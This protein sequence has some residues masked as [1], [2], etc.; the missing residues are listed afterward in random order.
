MF[1]LCKWYLFNHEY[2]CVLIGWKNLDVNLDIFADTELK[3]CWVLTKSLLPIVPVPYLRILNLLA[4]NAKKYIWDF[5]CTPFPPTNLKGT[6]MLIREKFKWNPCNNHDMYSNDFSSPRWL[7]IMN[8]WLVE[9]FG[10]GLAFVVDTSSE[11]LRGSQSHS[12]SS[13]FVPH[14]LHSLLY[15]IRIRIVSFIIMQVKVYTKTS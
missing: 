13:F 5:Y 4:R 3:P 11:N 14:T 12:V 2:F 1:S 7:E 10:V 8:E 15:C 9:I 6:S